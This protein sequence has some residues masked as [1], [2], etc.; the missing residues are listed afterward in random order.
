MA[1]SVITNAADQI[2]SNYEK[3]KDKFAEDATSSLGQMDFLN[4]MI[5][6]LQNQDFNNPQSDIEFIAQMAQFSS[7]EAQQENLQYAQGNYANSLIGKSVYIG[8]YSEEEGINV[9]D[10]GVVTGIYK[11]GDSY[12]ISMNGKYYPLKSVVS[13]INSSIEVKPSTDAEETD[14]DVAEDNTPDVT[15]EA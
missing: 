15:E 5:A 13:V 4:L 11:D 9:K 14:T 2:A 1:D 12:K 3:Y 6:Q 8:S 10:T 7:L